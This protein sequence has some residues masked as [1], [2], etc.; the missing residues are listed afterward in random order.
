MDGDE[1]DPSLSVESPSEV[2][3]SRS[4]QG[5]KH[6][7]RECV[8]TSRWIFDRACRAHHRSGRGMVGCA[9]LPMGETKAGFRDQTSGEQKH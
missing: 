5:R 2:E 3:M 1:E 9:S 7:S 4:L 8:K 6:E